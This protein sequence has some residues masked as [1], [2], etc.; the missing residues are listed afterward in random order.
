[1]KSTDVKK[2]KNMVEQLQDMTTQ[3]EQM[4][5]SERAELQAMSA[6]KR[7]LADREIK[8]ESDIQNMDIARV[9]ID[10]VIEDLCKT[11]Y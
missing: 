7:I 8:M 1:M 4:L 5:G 2:L 3:L 11:I 6:R 10:S 9:Q